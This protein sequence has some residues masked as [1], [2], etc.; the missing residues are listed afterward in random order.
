MEGVGDFSFLNSTRFKLTLCLGMSVFFYLFLIFFLPFGVSNYNPD[1]TY[2]ADFLLEI[3]N[4]FF[5]SLG[6]LLLNEF[7]LKPILLK[8]TSRKAIIIWS[9][10]TLI[11]LGLVN[12][13]TYN[14]LGNWHDFHVKSALGFIFNCASVFVFPMVGIFMVYRYRAIQQ[15]V[16][17]LS[18]GELQKLSTDQLITFM[19]DG[20]KDKIAISESTFLYAQSH[21]NYV[22]IFHLEQENV[23]KELIRASL[24]KLDQNISHPAIIRCHRS[25][26]VNLRHV[27]AVKGGHKASVL[28]LGPGDISVPVSRSYRE[29]V[30]ARLEEVKNMS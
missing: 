28:Y 3:F 18:G 11:L 2:T 13:L 10:W 9:I 16:E 7:A 1:H 30:T 5:V 21:D 8:S 4:F 19:G 17:M 24:S 6:V 22:A 15:R 27:L 23:T 29:E 26:L 14:I 20:N 12:F 25:F